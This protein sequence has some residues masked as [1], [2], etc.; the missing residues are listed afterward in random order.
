MIDDGYNANPLSVE[1]AVRQL[2]STKARLGAKRAIFIFGDM[3]ELGAESAKLHQNVAQLPTFE[4]IDKVHCVGKAIRALY[5]ILPMEQKGYCVS[6]VNDMLPI[7]NNVIEQGDVVLIK[8][9][10]SLNLRAVID[11]LNTIISRP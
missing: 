7:L 3:L 6:Q 1:A 8:G 10:N 4:S 9:S 11:S 5:Q 2:A